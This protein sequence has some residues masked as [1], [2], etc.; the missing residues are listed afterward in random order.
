MQTRSQTRIE[1]GQAPM[2]HNSNV[3]SLPEPP[4]VAESLGMKRDSREGL[5]S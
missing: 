4:V 5:K 2:L 1:E 3:T